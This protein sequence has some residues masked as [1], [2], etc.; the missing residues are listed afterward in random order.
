[1]ST[2]VTWTA[3][4]SGDWSDAANWSGD[5]VPNSNDNVTIATS[6]VQTITYDSGSDTIN[7]LSVG[8]DHFILA[9]GSLEILTTA[10]FDD[11]FVQT[12]GSLT[13]GTLTV[14]KSGTLTGGSATGSTVLDIGSGI[15][16]A[17]YTLAGSAVL[18]NNSV[19]SQ[20]GQITV[21]DNTGVDATIDNMAKGTYNI[22]GDYNINGG[23]PSAAFDNAGALAKTSGSGTAIIAVDIVSTGTL[24]ANA[25]GTLEFTGPNNTVGGVLT[26]A[27]QI[28]FT[29]DVALAG[30]TMTVG[31][32]G[33]FG[34][35]DITLGSNTVLTGSVNV[36]GNGVGTLDLN[37]NTLTLNG[38]ASTISESYPF[39]VQGNG[40][41]VNAGTLGANDVLF[42][43][44][45]GFTNSGTVNQSGLIGIGDGSAEASSFI[46]A[47]GGV[48]NAIGGNTD[49][50]NAGTTS[51]SSFTNEGVFN[52]EAGTGNA[53]ALNT[54]F[55]NGTAG[56]V[57]IASGSL[58]DND[59]LTNSGTLTGAGTLKVDGTLTLNAGTALSTGT[60]IINNATMNVNASLSDPDVF[61]DSSVD[62]S[63]LL[64]LGANTL[65]L[66]G[67]SNTFTNSIAGSEKLAGIGTLA[68]AGTLALLSVVVGGGSTL[69]NTGTVN[70]TGTVTV[71]DSTASFIDN[72]AG[73]VWNAGNGSAA[74]EIGAS[75]LSEFTNYGTFNGTATSGNAVTLN[76]NF[77]NEK[78]ATI[79]DQLG[80]ITNTGSLVND[81]TISGGTLVLGGT[82]A[83]GGSTTFNAGTS[84]TVS[85]IYITNFAV[86]TLDTNLTYKGSFE[87]SDT[88]G[89][90]VNLNKHS[91]TLSGPA[92]FVSTDYYQTVDG[93]GTLTTKGDTLLSRVQ[94]GEGAA[95]VNDSLITASGSLEIG[96][97][98]GLASSFT[99]AANHIFDMTSDA[100]ISIGNSM[101]SAFIN[102]GLFEMTANSGTGTISAPFVNNGT[103]TV[104]SGGTLEFIAGSLTGGGVIN[105]TVTQDHA[106][107]IFITAPS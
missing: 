95:W 80:V 82:N 41:L 55:T 74:L 102:N 10:T 65:T 43:A 106:G 67:S 11:G 45:A 91:L 18:N 58:L 23:A 2:T 104:S 37:A 13:S 83:V 98:S 99:N 63:T 28:A 84:L 26:G 46:N 85:E 27:G 16:L 29:G 89:D 76:T 77:I 62:G 38:A 14:L 64:D 3:T 86:M 50:L 30:G 34:G 12:G 1:M 33:I 56:T 20:T 97:K 35:A 75:G 48:W 51:G 5:A 9:G 101:A 93:A 19:A 61:I 53:V 6:S 68:N 25:N 90:T 24:S 73:A 96:D 60:I 81:G 8:K 42:I 39:Y 78:G 105:G 100:A 88:S 22:A 92:S 52:A 87:H 31:T 4:S 94:L 17:N 103:I 72:A 47:S 36:S 59:G 15:A 79:A 40:T 66:T 71:G 21:G 69:K 49:N 70:Q 54:N 57:D 107:D 7:E 44:A 32:L